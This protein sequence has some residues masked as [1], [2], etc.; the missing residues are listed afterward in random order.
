MDILTEPAGTRTEASTGRL[1]G[2]EPKVLVIEDTVTSAAVL[3]RHLEKMGCTVDCA[4]NGRLGVETFAASD[5]G[6]YAAILMDIRMPVLDGLGAA[7]A[8]RAQDHVRLMEKLTEPTEYDEA[9]RK[10]ARELMERL[11]PED[12]A[13]AVTFLASPAAGQISGTGLDVDGGLNA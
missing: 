12:I 2:S 13:A 4:E 9:D 11:S 1:P 10:V 6:A 7:K 8:I 5:P 3:A